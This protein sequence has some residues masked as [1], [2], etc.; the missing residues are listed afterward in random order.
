MILNKNQPLYNY[1]DYDNFGITDNMTDTDIRNQLYL[2]SSMYLF[3]LI[4]N[5]DEG[6]NSFNKY[7]YKINK[8]KVNWNTHRK[9]STNIAY[10][11][12]IGCLA[13]RQDS[14]ISH[15]MLGG[16]LCCFDIGMKT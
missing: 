8:N 16:R 14:K 1:L 13:S 7:I 9:I 3:K 10:F 4:N 5:A 2:V 12:D 6:Q 15:H 11:S